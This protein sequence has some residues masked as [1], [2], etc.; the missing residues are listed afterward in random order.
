MSFS[1]LS[2]RQV[3]DVWSDLTDAYYGR[4]GYGGN[5]AEVYIYRL[6]PYGKPHRK[7]YVEANATLLG[8][9]RCFEERYPD[10][11]ITLY[12]TRNDDGKALGPW[13]AGCEENH[14]HHIRIG[15]SQSVEGQ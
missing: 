9:L 14:R 5:T 2:M 7:D 6:L 12:A 1:N 8:I 13:L 11:A 4:N 3:V 15:K 10:A